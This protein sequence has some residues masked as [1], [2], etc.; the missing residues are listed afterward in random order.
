MLMQQRHLLSTDDL[1]LEEIDK[2]LV[3][4]SE[5]LTPSG[6]SVFNVDTLVGRRFVLAFFEP[7]TRTRLSFESAIHRTG[8]SCVHFAEAG[9]SVEKGESLDETIRTIES[10]GFDGMI[11]RHAVNGTHA[12]IAARTSM[13]VINAG[14]G[15]M[16]HPTQALLDA[17]TIREKFGRIDGVKVVIIGDLLHSRVARS[18]TSILRRLGAEVAW[19]APESLAPVDRSGY[20]LRF[21]DA[22]SAMEWA[23]VAY[24]LRIQ[25]E[26]IVSD[27][28]PDVAFYRE[29]YAVDDSLAVQYPSVFVMHPGP[30]NIGVELDASVL[31]LPQCL[32]HRQ[33]THGVA[34]RM[35]VLEQHSR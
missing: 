30:V 8:A 12:H 11:I 23:D 9:S 10:M 3:R 6:L 20:S 25:R 35:A 21:D 33:V 1:T 29:H 16:S 24:L 13:S 2:I 19:C 27:V 15:T 17:S 18:T 5:L 31:D 22:R 28:V 34:V 32:V 4:A 7:S 14:E 26:R